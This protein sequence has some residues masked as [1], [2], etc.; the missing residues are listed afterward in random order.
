MY[1]RIVFQKVRLSADSPKRT[2]WKAFDTASEYLGRVYS[3]YTGGWSAVE[4]DGSVSHGFSTRYEAAY[5]LLRSRDRR[6]V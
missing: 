2:E 6:A 3:L 4:E 5:S 1:P